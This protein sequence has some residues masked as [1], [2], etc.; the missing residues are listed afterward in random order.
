[1]DGRTLAY[2]DYAW[3][4]AIIDSACGNP[5][6]IVPA[7]RNGDGLPIGIQIAAPHYAEAEL[8]H[9]GKLIEQL[10]LACPK[11]AGY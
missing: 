8:I 3:P 5:A 11:P 9:F 7:G 10:G 6:L 2:V 4:Y 1:M